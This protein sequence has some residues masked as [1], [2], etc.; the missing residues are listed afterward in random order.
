MCRIILWIC[1]IIRKRGTV[2]LLYHSISPDSDI[3]IL[4]NIKVS[5]ENFEKQMQYIA[6]KKKVISLAT[7]LDFAEK[8][9]RL[10]NTIVITFDDGYLDNCRIALP[11]LEKYGLPATF[12]IATGLM[13]ALSVFDRMNYLV[14][15]TKRNRVTMPLRAG[16]S[17][18]VSLMNSEDRQ[19]FVSE[20]AYLLENMSPDRQSSFLRSLSAELNGDTFDIERYNPKIM[21]SEEECK[22]MS[23]YDGIAVGAHTVSHANLA[24][25]SPEE[26]RKEIIRSKEELERLTGSQAKFFAYPYGRRSNYNNN[27]IEILKQSGFRCALTNEVGVNNGDCDPFQIKRIHVLN[28]SG[29]VFRFRLLGYTGAPAKLFRRIHPCAQS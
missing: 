4:N 11:I 1:T 8:G 10:K 25:L 12:F 6:K 18:E 22:V 16:I 2:I 17:K 21:M 15:T 14:M 19:A 3:C 13:G 5:P 9:K 23:M 27:V 20:A 28:D 7:F 29:L 24:R 26:A